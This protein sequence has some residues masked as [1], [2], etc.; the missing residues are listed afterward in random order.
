[1]VRC[2]KITAYLVALG[3]FLALAIDAA[4][5]SKETTDLLHEALRQA[6]GEDNLRA[7]R[8][9][10]F[11]ALGHRN[12]LEES[13]R[14]EGPYVV[15]YDQ[16]S[17]WRD[18]EHS[19]WKQNWEFRWALPPIFKGSIVVA[20]GVAL[21][22]SNVG[23]R[24]GSRQQVQQAEETLEL[25]PERIL[26][27]ALDAPDVHLEPDTV[28]QSVPHHVVAFTWKNSPVRIFLNADTYLP[29]AVEW[30]RPYP[31]DQFWS[32]WGDVTTRVFYSFWW[33]CPNGIH[34]PLQWDV[35]RNG[36]PDRVITI[37]NVTLNP[38]LPAD[39][40]AILPDVRE[41]FCKRGT[42]T[43]DEQPFGLPDQPPQ[44]V[45]K[46]VVLIPGRWNTTLIKQNDGIVVLEA[47]AASGY[48]AQVIA[49]AQRRWPGLPFKAVITTSDAWAHLAGV[50]EY[51]ARGIPI[52][53]LDLNVP[54]LQ[55]L[56]DALYR[57]FPDLLAKSPRKP[58]FHIVSAKTVLGTGPNRLEIYP[59][60]TE[61]MER[62]MIVYFPQ[63]KLLYASA[64]FEEDAPG[65]YFYPQTVW[66]VKHAVEREHLEVDTVFTMHMLAKPWSD[67][68]RAIAQAEHGG[69]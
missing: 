13:E 38:D 18:L 6:G 41:N 50:R 17:E 47:P 64:A 58:D 26:V 24:P 44:E 51:V 29:T 27:T 16:I 7:L 21:R 67:I 45:A 55:R 10:H 56:V 20:D 12:W 63:Y 60:R 57:T 31:Y 15:E 9:V 28:L 68:D 66:E 61:T 22:T 36:L 11:D 59:L 23:S 46:D 54:I 48:S 39:E 43:I 3:C 19:R 25:G 8:S 42:R 34:Y 4:G 30:T 52:Y 37:T 49:E 62:G 5:A 33:L 2:P 32:T 53:A 65:E 40:F 69:K 14:P 1:M 35:F